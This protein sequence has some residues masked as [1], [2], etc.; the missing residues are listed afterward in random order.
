MVETDAMTGAGASIT[1]ALNTGA[2]DAGTGAAAAA[3]RA[4]SSSTAAWNSS[5]TASAAISSTTSSGG[6]AN[7]SVTSCS[8][9][10][11]YDCNASCGRDVVFNGRFI[12]T[13]L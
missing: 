7:S 8:R 9:L 6:S 4:C 10:S 3:S 13:H 2:T 5:S 11:R 12:R 1:G